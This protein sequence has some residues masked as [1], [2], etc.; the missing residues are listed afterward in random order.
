MRGP[1]L[2]VH[3]TA[4]DGIIDS[5]TLVQMAA[6][7]GLSAIAITDHDSVEGV[8]SALSAADDTDIVVIPGVELSSVHE[9]RDVH[10]LGYF[11]DT[12]SVHF[13]QHLD[14]LRTARV[15]RAETIVGLLHDA[16]YRVFLEDVLALADGGAV[17]RSHVARV[18]V[19]AGHA[20]SV[21]EA[22][23]TLLGRGRP[24]YVPKDV[25]SPSEVIGIIHD[26]GGLAV[27]AHPGITRVDDILPQLIDDGLDGLEVYHGEHD[28]P[29]RERYSQIADSRGLLATGGSDFHHP[30][31]PGPGLGG[32]EVPKE[33]LTNLLRA[34]R[35]AGC[36]QKS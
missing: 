32:A 20:Q 12:S 13:R 26:A 5:A 36:A 34:A 7:L 1:D 23:E 3:S 29:T 35:D 33:V 10:I 28:T 24:F 16:G 14:D 19:T 8:P 27:L 18:L 25:R 2:H 11:I 6:A 9:S 4:S 17:G 31:A 15:H 21:G 22:F 30:H